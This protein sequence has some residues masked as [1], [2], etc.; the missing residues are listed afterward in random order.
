M[1]IK[2]LLLVGV[3]ALSFGVVSEVGMAQQ[4][5]FSR[6]QIKTTPVAGSVYML[7]GAGGNIGVSAG[8]DG[9][10]IVDDQFAPL[11]DKI[12]VALRSINPGAL[13]FGWFK[14]RRWR[15][16]RAHGAAPG[17]PRSRAASDSFGVGHAGHT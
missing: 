1:M 11:A 10:L 3:A 8:A 9:V 15:R 16:K 2:R 13:R 17:T 6:V 14:R 12:R 4:Q 5:D 7:E